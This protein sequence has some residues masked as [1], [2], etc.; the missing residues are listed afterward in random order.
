MTIKKDNT[1]N[2]KISG[3]ID[4]SFDN[5]T[6]HAA[7]ILASIG[8]ASA[9]GKIYDDF[10]KC[11]EA[12]AEYE[13]ALKK[14]ESIADT[15]VASM[16]SIRSE[17]TALSFDTGVSAADLSESVY[18][19]ISASVNTAD[20]VDFVNTANQLAVGGFT[21]A[22][23][24]VDVLTTAINAYK[25]SADDAGQIS[26]YLIMTQNKGKTTVDELASA[27]GKVIP[28]ASAY[29]VQMDNLSTAYAITTANGI[30][31]AEAT[32]YIKSMLNELADTGSEVSKILFSET[33]H[34]FSELNEAGHSLG[35][36]LTV[37]G[38]S[39]DGDATAFSNLWSSSEGA[40]AA[41]SLYGSGAEKYNSVLNEMQNSAG[42]TSEA[43][44]LMTETTEFAHQRMV[45]GAE[46]VSIAI[47]EVLNPAIGDF[48][49]LFADVEEGVAKVIEEHPA[50]I[51]SFASA[52]AALGVFTAATT[53]Y[54]AATSAAGIASKALTA[55]W[56]SNP[57]FLVVTGIAA[58]AAA[59]YGAVTAFDAAA[60]KAAD[61]SNDLTASSRDQQAELDTL[62]SKYDEVCEKSGENSYEAQKLKE[63]VDK[64]TQTYDENKETIGALIAESDELI[65]RTKE[66][67][68][69]WNEKTK[70]IEADTQG[71]LALIDVIRELN[72]MDMSDAAFEEKM[73]AVIAA[74]NDRL[75]GL[76][77]SY[78]DV[79]KNTAKATDATE[80]YVEAEKK[81]RELEEGTDAW[82][83]AIQTKS[84]LEIQIGEVKTNKEAVQKDIDEQMAD[85]L[86]EVNDR[87]F[88][89]YS[90]LD[91]TNY[92]EY[93]RLPDDIERSYKELDSY[94]EKL[95]EL[96][97]SLE[98]NE[99][100]IK[101]YSDAMSNASGKIA[102]SGKINSEYAK[103]MEAVQPA[104]SMM[105][106]SMEKLAD[107]YDD[108]HKEAYNSIS[109]QIGLFTKMKVSVKTT[110][111][112]ML[113]AFKS[114][115]EYLDKY[116]KNIKKASKIGLN[117]D[118]LSQL[119]DG[120]TEAAGQLDVIV[121]KYKELEEADGKKAA[122]RWIKDFNKQFKAV[123]KGKEKFADTVGRM[124]S[125][126][127]DGMR[128]MVKD[129]KTAIKDMD[130]SDAARTAAERTIDAY[131]AAI[132]SKT[133][134][135][136]DAAAGMADVVP[137]AF[138][139]GDKKANK[140]AKQYTKKNGV[141]DVAF[142]ATGDIITKPTLTFVAEAGY[143]E[144]IIPINNS[145]RAFALWEETGKR[146]GAFNGIRN[147][148]KTASGS[149]KR[150]NKESTTNAAYT[151][152]T[153][154]T[155]NS[156]NTDTTG[157]SVQN[158]TFSPTINISGNASKA[159][160]KSAI[161]DA[162][163]EFKKMM[164][165]YNKM[166]KRVGVGR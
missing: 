8:A 43:Y 93:G 60:D 39:V 111:N 85:F 30:A 41:L 42:A 23:T 13:T 152:N 103:G 165:K 117:E 78:E 83:G 123:E 131:I 91:A 125:D 61:I 142:N 63:E 24:A 17:L 77:L 49:N 145:K 10:M 54:T 3:E 163:E 130:L 53:A 65:K 2:I 157:K 58:V 14:V 162:F 15:S 114:Q 107:S 25:L 150:L 156:V 45:T 18:N 95:E 104:I 84:D 132:K 153:V 134:E 6:K 96:E 31:T 73:Q 121:K 159:E 105:R 128:D 20:A 158:I 154:N 52:A 38:D 135:V 122:E 133:S 69:S 151:T 76:N 11:S 127:N 155:A 27:M 48:Y 26:D 37:I 129:A 99:K 124:E 149:L 32:T 140:K 82:V 120:S 115:K 102:M 81:Q 79:V 29:S 88:D 72:S 7:A 5:A 164:N 112:D 160:V 75:P 22:T 4:S 139:L 141:G 28:L 101:A 36:V 71:A 119:S 144:A 98:D 44:K 126:F 116:N 47:G 70:A 147:K 12:A 16:D 87:N 51:A 33:G 97:K 46:N 146:L 62:K 56:D 90:L 74:L 108:A 138:D 21:N 86:Q 100:Q 113:K 1:L 94:D 166:Q 35:D 89:T 148:E 80:K 137:N 59:T 67:A 136:A 57:L 68:G 50:L 9:M 143:D 161:G 92:E 40:T 34:S 19:A 66:Q 64:L 55:I 109:S 118:I 110:T 106:T